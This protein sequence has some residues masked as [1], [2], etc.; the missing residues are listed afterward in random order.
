MVLDMTAYAMPDLFDDQDYC[1]CQKIIGADMGGDCECYDYF[2]YA[3]NYDICN[4]YE[5]DDGYFSYYCHNVDPEYETAY[6]RDYNFVPTSMS[7]CLC[8]NP[9]SYDI[10]GW[11]NDART[12]HCMVQ[13]GGN[14]EFYF[15]EHCSGHI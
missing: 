11:W 14:K 15:W 4:A 13:Y 7:G 6:W 5:E 1:W 3:Q 8:E 9:G 10:Y 2:G 12:C